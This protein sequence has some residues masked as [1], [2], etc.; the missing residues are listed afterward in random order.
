MNFR[1]YTFAEFLKFSRKKT[2]EDRRFLLRINSSVLIN[3][4]ISSSNMKIDNET[5]VQLGMV[6]FDKALKTSVRRASTN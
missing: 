3:Y 5:F 2:L 6:R 4:N 1:F